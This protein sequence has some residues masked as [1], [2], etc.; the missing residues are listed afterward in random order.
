M[1]YIRKDITNQPNSLKEVQSTPG[2]S[3]DYCNRDDIRQALLKEQGFICAYCMRGIDDQ[4]D[5]NGRPKVFI[6]HYITQ[7]EDRSLSLSYLNMLG[8]CNG[9]DGY[10]EHLQ[11]CDRSR[12]NTP[13]KI[14]PRLVRCEDLIKYTNGGE[15]YSD[16]LE[17]NNDLDK[18]LNLNKPR[19]L[20]EGRRIA[21]DQVR[22]NLKSWSEGE[23][24]RAINRWSELNQD[25]RFPEFCQAAIHY[26]KKKLRS[27]R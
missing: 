27:R 17:V 14:D 2:T 12:G 23:I 26:L 15:I 4:R 5:K 20:V 7:S 24:R 1:K 3:F 6:E 18:T 10:P 19:Y 16:D 9:N 8:V 21:I 13:L 11:H 25:G 22:R